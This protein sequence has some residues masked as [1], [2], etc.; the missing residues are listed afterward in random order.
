MDAGESTSTTLELPPGLM[1]AARMTPG[2]L[3]LELALTLFQQNKLSF[4]KARELAGMSVL[5]F[6]REMGK[7]KI[8]PHYGVRE[9]DEDMAT[10]KSMGLL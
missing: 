9:F 1:Q 7:R 3:K 8:S 10:L 2:E 5:E 4:G 6:Q